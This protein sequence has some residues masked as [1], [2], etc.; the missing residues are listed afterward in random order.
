MD[1]SNLA[2][3]AFCDGIIAKCN[4]LKKKKKFGKFKLMKI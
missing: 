4:N 1:I 2:F 3:D